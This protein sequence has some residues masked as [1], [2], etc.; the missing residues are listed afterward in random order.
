MSSTTTLSGYTPPHVDYQP[1]SVGDKAV[2][3]VASQLS[4]N[5]GPAAHVTLSPDALKA[6]MA[7]PVK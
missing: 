5:R 4:P 6:M 2:H 3:Q 1:A 7:Q